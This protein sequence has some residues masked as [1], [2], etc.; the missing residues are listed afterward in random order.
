MSRSLMIHMGRC[1]STV[2]STQ[3]RQ[4]PEMC[5]RGEIYERL[6]KAWEKL[7]GDLRSKR[8]EFRPWTLPAPF[9]VHPPGVPLDPLARLDADIDEHPAE[10]YGFEVKPFHWRLL[11]C[12]PGAFLQ[13]V[14]ARGFDR[15]ILL[16]R[17]NALRKIVSSVVSRQ[18]RQF[19]STTPL[20]L[21]PITLDPERV[22]LD[23][24]DGPLLETLAGYEAQQAHLGALLAD[25]DCLRLVYEDH[26]EADPAV[27]YAQVRDHIGLTPRDDIEIK[28]ARTTDHPLDRVIRN[29]DEVAE[30][31]S[32]TR[33]EWMLER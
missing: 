24:N 7:G 17:R 28:L 14:E 11:D 15:F 8:G 25:R 21:F 33:W 31:L 22:S 30:V 4:H 2:V 10:H 20:G 12:D 3:L 13:S 18:R 23:R 26:V 5:W 6:F 16:W 32:G 9:E 27:A 19:H 29:F 1:G